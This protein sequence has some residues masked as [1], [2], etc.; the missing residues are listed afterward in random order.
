MKFLSNRRTAIG[1]LLI[2]FSCVALG[3]WAKSKQ[4]KESVLHD[5]EVFAHVINKVK[6]F[7]VDEV[8]THRLI[9]TAIED[10]LKELD[11]HSQFLSG[12]DFEDLMLSTQGQF[13]GLGIYISFRDNYPTVISPIE[14]TPAW[15][16]GIQTGDQIVEIEGQQTEGWQVQKAVR[17]L[18]G[19]PN[20]NVQFKISRPGLSERI[21]YILVREEIKVKS[22]TYSGVFDGYGYVK[23]ASFSRNTRDELRSALRDIEVE[24]NKGLVLDLRSNPGGLLQAATDVSE[25]FLDKDKLIVFTKG[26]YSQN[27]HKYYARKGRKFKDYP[28]VVMINGASASASEIVAGAIQDW[29]AGLVVGQTSFGKGTVQTVFSLSDSQAVKLTTAKYYTPT[30]RSIHKDHRSEPAGNVTVGTGDGN[31]GD[32]LT[33]SSRTRSMVQT[34]DNAELGDV[35]RPLFRTAAGRDVF[36]GGGIT[37]D[38]AFEPQKYG[39]LERRLERDALFFSFAIDYSTS[40]KV[41]RDFR[42]TPQVLVSFKQLL[43][44]R[45]FEYEE[46]KFKESEDYIKR[47]ITREIVSKN[48]GRKD[49][50]RVMLK[51]DVEFQHVLRIFKEAPTLKAMY[52]YAEQQ[53]ATKKASLK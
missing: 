21:E 9:T 14:G 52:D 19:E 28:I 32:D 37:P 33:T 12:L 23:L 22:V 13:G 18:R 39:E 45:E 31:D 42:V 48:F 49:M 40:H 17:Y 7:Y 10:M 24:G 6:S 43:A 51:H 35:S 29:D 26:R 50:Y 36:G 41:G 47:A 2:I 8:D 34:A 44:D 25:L 20:T 5:L 1:L 27:N 46:E 11:P 30:G 4:S 3:S 16:A 38:L 15:R 53:N